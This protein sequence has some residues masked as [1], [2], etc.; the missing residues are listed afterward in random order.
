VAAAFGVLRWAGWIVLAVLLLALARESIRRTVD[1]PVYH[2]VAR[3]MLRGDYSIYPAAVY[4]GTPMPSHGFRYAPVIAFLMMPIG[5]LPI[6]IAA[7]LL[8]ALKLAAAAYMGSVVARRTGMPPAHRRYLIAAFLIVGGYVAEEFRYGNVHFLTVAAMVFAFDTAESGRTLA[9]SLALGL[10]IATKV[11]PLALLGY[12][13]IRRRA[14]VCVATAAV[15]LGLAL[16]PAA[17]MGVEANTR[18]LRAFA[19]Y[20]VQ[21]VDEQDNYAL[22]GVLVRYLTTEHTGDI[23]HLPASVA[24][25]PP[26]VVTVIWLLG[27]AAMVLASLVVIAP[28]SRDPAVRLLE[29]SIVLT[30]IVLAAPHTQRRYFVSLFVP[31]LALLAVLVA[32]R[33]D[34]TTRHMICV[35]LA[36]LAAS[37]TI[38][39]LVFGGRRLALLY[40][41]ASPYFFGT[42]VLFATLLVVTARLKRAAQPLAVD[43]A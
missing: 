33:A 8:Y 22:R 12:F 39:P 9:P 23:S 42:L 24:D 35:G 40:E 25:L 14:A 41:A 37:G 15:L 28:E 3:E 38:L 36:G 16:A 43:S 30:G 20:A 21:K 5:W 2:R 13:A 10:A 27:V 18:L 26:A 4:D 6:E 17:W 32:R 29:L 19:T 7:L 34:R 11:T 31:A 1:L